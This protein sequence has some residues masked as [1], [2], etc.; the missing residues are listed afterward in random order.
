MNV[1]H[2][3]GPLADRIGQAVEIK[4][5]GG[6]RDVHQARLKPY[7]QR[8]FGY[9]WASVGWQHDLSPAGQAWLL[10][11]CSKQQVQGGAT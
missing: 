2:R 10:R 9:R 6:G 11:Q 7:I 5:K 1:H 3:Q 8:H 4:A